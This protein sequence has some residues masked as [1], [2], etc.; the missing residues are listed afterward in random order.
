MLT[1][2]PQATI[3]NVTGSHA[4]KKS[5]EQDKAAG[6]STMQKAGEARDSSQ[7]YGKWE[8]MAGNATGCDGMK[9]E[10]AASS[11]QD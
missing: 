5:G 7:G 4:W 2:A 10:G 6:L 11:K 9:K 3:G 8:E 1:S